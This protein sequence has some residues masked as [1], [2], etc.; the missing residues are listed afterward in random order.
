MIDSKVSEHA[1]WNWKASSI[2]ETN[3]PHQA[4]IVVEALVR[5]SY[6]PIIH[7]I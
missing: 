7:L 2:V 6:F 4:N 5:L 3:H 1:K